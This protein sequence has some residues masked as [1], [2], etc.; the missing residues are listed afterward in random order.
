MLTE[1]RTLVPWTCQRVHCSMASV[2]T[3]RVNSLMRPVLSAMGMNSAGGTGPMPGSDQRANASAPT[4][5]SLCVS[6][7]GWN[8]TCSSPFSI[9]PR[10]RETSES[11]SGR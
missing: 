4:T 11:A 10:N 7:C 5:R 1:T 2:R 9:A 3:C 6:N 8:A